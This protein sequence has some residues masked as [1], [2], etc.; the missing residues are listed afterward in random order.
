MLLSALAFAFMAALVKLLQDI[1]V[2]EKVFFRNFVALFIA[3]ASVLKKKLP[4]FGK[5]QNQ[6]YLLARSLLGAT[7]MALYFYAIT[8]LLLADSAMLNKLSPFFVTVFAVIF[9]KE[10]ITQIRV[11]TLA[12]AFAAALLIIKPRFDLSI[13]PA[14]A[15]LGSAVFAGAAYTMVRFLRK[16]EAPP[17]IVFYFAAVSTLIMLPLMLLDFKMPNLTQIVFLIGTGIFAAI[18]QFSLTY[19]YKYAPASEVAIYNYANILFSAII[20]YVLW[21][22]VSDILSIIGG[23]LI[24]SMSVLNFWET[25][26]KKRVD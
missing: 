23:F 6:K 9:L 17:T 1:P 25:N 22:E 2:F 14:L 15:G 16:K 21:Y 19:A 20:G 5:K 3:L 13:L 24:I 11:I 10:K 4:I 7:G 8:N 18:G 12:V 26:L